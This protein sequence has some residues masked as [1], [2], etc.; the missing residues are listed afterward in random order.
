MKFTFCG[1]L[2]MAVSVSAHGQSG[3]VGRADSI[4]DASDS[5]TMARTLYGQA[6]EEMARHDTVAALRELSRAANAWPLQPAYANALLD[7]ALRAHVQARMTEAIRLANT[8][9]YALPSAEDTGSASM[10]RVAELKPLLAQQNELRAMKNN[11]REF[12]WLNDSTL[13]PEGLSF[14][15]R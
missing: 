15:A 12:R 8:M 9:G 14:D 5:A 4:R 6:R 1:A 7:L 13:F 2:F 10:L 11:S 3:A